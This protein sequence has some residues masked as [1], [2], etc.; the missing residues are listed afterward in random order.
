MSKGVSPVVAEV[1]LLGIAIASVSSAAI[2]IG[3]TLEGIQNNVEDWLG[4]R[5]KVEASEISIDYGYNRSGYL[6]VDVRNTGSRT[7]VVEEKNQKNWNMYIDD[8]P[9]EWA[10]MSGS[11]YADPSTT[12]VLLN[13]TS[14]LTLN[15]TEKFTDPGNSTGIEFTGPYEIRANYE[16]FSQGGACES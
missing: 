3:G 12:Q 10:Y 15:T 6:I 2:F 8:L 4:L 11:S 7:L 13:P 5:D 16:C 1:L 9:Q 14:V